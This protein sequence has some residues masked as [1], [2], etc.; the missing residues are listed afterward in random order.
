MPLYYL[1]FTLMLRHATM[2]LPPLFAATLRHYC[3]FSPP[4]RAFAF[5]DGFRCCFFSPILADYTFTIL[6]RFAAMTYMRYITHYAE[7]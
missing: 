2:L 1:R 6:I 3:R 4:L 5:F 7:R